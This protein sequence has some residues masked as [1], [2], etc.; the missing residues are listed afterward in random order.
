[1][2]VSQLKLRAGQQL[3]S[4]VDATTVI[5]VRSPSDEVTIT[6]GGEVMVDPRAATAAAKKELDP[7]HAGEVLLGKRYVDEAR[8][9]ELLC[10][11]AG[12]GQ[13][14]LDGSPLVIK[15]SKPLPASD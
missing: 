15:S 10:T 8:G 12:K 6:C 9:L 3:T 2:E 5:V 1:V 14:A 4:A 11:K 7:S 13:L